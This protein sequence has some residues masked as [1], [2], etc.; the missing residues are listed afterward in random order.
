MKEFRAPPLSW[1]IDPDQSVIR[2]YFATPLSPDELE[3]ARK[4][5]PVEESQVQK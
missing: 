5:M 1:S 3:F 4:R 2:E